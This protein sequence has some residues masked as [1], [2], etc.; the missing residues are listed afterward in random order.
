MPSSAAGWS[1]T[2][3]AACRCARTRIRSRA[4]RRGSCRTQSC[5]MQL[6]EDAANSPADSGGGKQG[7]IGWQTDQDDGERKQAKIAAARMH[8]H[9]AGKKSAEHPDG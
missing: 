5:E 9:N 8:Q 6:F 2:C 7:D 1:I 4:T 3:P